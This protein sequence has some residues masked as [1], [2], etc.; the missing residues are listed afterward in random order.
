MNRNAILMLRCAPLA[1]GL[2]SGCVVTGTTYVRTAPRPYYYGRREVII[3]P[4]PAVVVV[5]PPRAV[6]VTPAP[7]PTVVVAPTPG[8][9]VIVVHRPLPA[10][11]VES[12]PAPPGAEYVWIPGF[13]AA[14]RD[15]WMWVKGHY[16]RPPQAGAVWVAPRHVQ[17]SA[18]E[19]EFSMGF[20]R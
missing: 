13:Y 6:V 1:A 7:P 12:I 16:E 11:L 10:A 18:T 5:P 2:L 17:R 15:D 20:W 14:S 19:Y 8:P 9:A 4:A 3:E